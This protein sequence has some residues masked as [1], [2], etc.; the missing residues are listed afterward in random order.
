MKRNAKNNF[1]N[2]LVIFMTC[3][4][5]GCGSDSETVASTPVISLSENIISIGH[6]GGMHTISV[7]TDSE[8]TAFSD[9][10]WIDC[11]SSM[12]KGEVN[13]NISENSTFDERRGTVTVK[14]GKSRTA[15]DVTQEARPE[16]DTT[17]INVPEGYRLV[18]NDEF[19]DSPTNMPDETLWYYETGDNGWGNN[20]IQKY[21]AGTSDGV[22]CAEIVDGILQISAR[23]AGDEVY[24]IRMN[25]RENWLYGY[26]EA[27]LMLPSGKGTWPAFWMLPADFRSWPEDGE[28]DIMEE[29]GYDPDVIHATIHCKAYNHSANTQ[30]SGQIRIE[31]SQQEF[32]VYAVEWTEDFIKGY[33]DGHCYFTFEND[34]KGNKD[35]WPFNVPFYLKLNLAWGGNWGGAQGIDESSLPATYKIDYVRVFQKKNN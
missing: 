28:I 25:T 20:E 35:T 14:A 19:N 21:I 5:S 2:F 30:K 18:W 17:G 34:G 9:N 32:H 22:T 1:N 33:V 24:S 12:E 29:V 7:D 26:F 13:I 10:G 8:W 23:K 3:I 27:R 16:M 4:M 31:G 11:Q 15:I 6:E